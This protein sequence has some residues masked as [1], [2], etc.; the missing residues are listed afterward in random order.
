MATPRKQPR[1]G[2]DLQQRG[3]NAAELILTQG[4]EL[5]FVFYFINFLSFTRQIDL[6]LRSRIIRLII[7]C[8]LLVAVFVCREAPLPPFFPFYRRSF[9]LLDIGKD[10]NTKSR[11]KIRPQN[12]L[13]MAEGGWGLLR[14][15][16]GGGGGGRWCKSVLLWGGGGAPYLFAILNAE[17][18]SNPNPFQ[19][20]K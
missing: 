5:L 15:F 14:D 2:G 8:E 4:R 1:K 11:T 18:N 9:S 12:Q 17:P 3:H 16:L 6:N 19:D 13:S 10:V 7:C 20:K